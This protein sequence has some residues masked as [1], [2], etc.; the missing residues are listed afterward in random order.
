M[1]SAW[2]AGRV[3]G[4]SEYS[5]FQF[6]FLGVGNFVAGVGEDFETVVLEGIVGGGNHEA[7][8]EGAGFGEPGDAGGGQN[9]R[10]FKLHTLPNQTRRYLGRQ[11][12]TGFP[13]IHADENARRRRMGQRPFAQRAAEGEDG[14]GVEGIPPGDPANTVGTE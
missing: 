5:F 6:E 2:L 11:R 3:I 13:G 8:G 14:A 12:G 10:N 4:E 9:S 1:E 7:R